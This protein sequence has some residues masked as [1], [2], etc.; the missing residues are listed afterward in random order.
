MPFEPAIDVGTAQADAEIFQ[1]PGAGNRT[2]G[3][4]PRVSFTYSAEAS[5][6]VEIYLAPRG[7]SA[8]EA[9]RVYLVNDTN[10]QFLRSCYPVWIE[11]SGEPW[12]L[13]ITK[14]DT[15]GAG[16]AFVR[17]EWEAGGKGR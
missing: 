11:P 17:I 10:D 15:G 13:F 16:S 4:L 7:G 6:L 9:N 2:S 8:S 1:F 5:E 12:S 3:E 14:P